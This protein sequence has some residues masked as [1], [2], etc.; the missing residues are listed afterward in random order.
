MR[1]VCDRHQAQSTASSTSPTANGNITI[2]FPPASESDVQAPVF[3][4]VFARVESRFNHFRTVIHD[5]SARLMA[6]YAID[7]EIDEQFKAV[8]AAKQ[9]LH[10]QLTHRNTLTPISLLPPEVLARVFHFLGFEDPACSAEQN[11]GWIRATHVCRFWR[12][13][14][15]DDSSLWAT[16][17]GISANTELISEMLARAKNAPLDIDIHL[18]GASS[19]E[20]LRMFP[21]HIS[22]TRELRFHFPCILYSDCVRD[23]YSREA[24]VLEHFE[25]RGLIKSPATYR[26]ESDGTT[27]FK[28]RAPRLRTL[29]LSQ[30]LIP[31]SLIPRR[32]LTQ[33]KI[34]FSK[35]DEVS[36]TDVLLCGNLNQLIDLLVNCSGLEILVLGC[37]LPPQL[38][39]IPRGRTIHLPRLSRLCLVGTN[40]RITNLMKMLKLPSTTTLHLHCIS[41]NTSTRD[42][43]LLLPI[44]SSQLQCPAPVE[45][46]SLSVTL[47]CMYHSLG[48]TA[49]TAV[50]T[51]RIGLF[52]GIEDDIDDII[53]MDNN[54]DSEF[55]LSFNGL[56]E[57]GHKTNLLE[58]TC[59]MLPISNLEFLFIS[60][61]DSLNLVELF[62]RC[63]KLTTMQV[64]GTGSLVRALTAPKV[65]NTRRRWNRKKRRDG[66]DSIPAQPAR[67]TA[68]HAHAPIFPKLKSLSLKGLDFSEKK[69]LS[70][71]LFDVVEKG[72][73]QRKAP[74]KALLKMLCIDDCAI[75]A[76]RANA[77]Q[78]LV[79]EFHWDGK[80]VFDEYEDFDD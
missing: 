14:A 76:R 57:L 4:E 58:R 11:L 17:S 52:Q 51:S 69:H 13:V 32:Q 34:V 31:W 62:K 46:K 68:A 8:D 70:G 55:V 22:H 41:E 30:V 28:G 66:S 39:Q 19:R 59:K 80:E 64:V 71:I 24:P 42:D 45:F 16:I 20:V 15:L 56:P 5:P 23:I 33:L 75:N 50:S 47:S 38:T 72:L 73:R 18:R 61:P 43:H 9:L 7:R 44:I 26:R 12:Q 6:I 29:F 36:T 65:T 67:G 35:L 48:V 27:L 79:E 74:R 37:C 60:V 1:Q 53:D 2:H 54:D 77:L 49:S 10:S 25:L 63:T 21:L 78:K 40:S 3:S